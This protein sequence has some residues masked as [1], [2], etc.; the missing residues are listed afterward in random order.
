MVTPIHA[1]RRRE[2]GI[3]PE[4][5]IDLVDARAALTVDQRDADAHAVRPSSAA[6]SCAEVGHVDLLA[7]DRDVDGGAEAAARARRRR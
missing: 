6:G 2:R 1:A 4:V 5:R 7:V 3:R